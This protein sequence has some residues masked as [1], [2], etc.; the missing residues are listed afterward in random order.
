M[1]VAD[2]AVLHPAADDLLGTADRVDA[3]AERIDVSRVEEVDAAFEGAVHDRERCRFIALQAKRHRAEAERRDAQSRA[4]KLAVSHEA[5]L[6]GSRLRAL[7]P[8]AMPGEEELIEQRREKLQ[9]LA[10]RGA[11]YPARA[12]RTHEAA[13]AIAAFETWEANGAQGDAPA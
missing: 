11:V 7:Y 1:R 5:P 2:A 9:R 3:A 8:T 4:A 6:L 13:T 10:E 12:T